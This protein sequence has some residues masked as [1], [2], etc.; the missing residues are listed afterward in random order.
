MVYYAINHCNVGPL[1]QYQLERQRVKPPPTL[2]AAAIFAIN[3]AFAPVKISWRYLNSNGSRVTALINEQTNEHSPTNGH[4]LALLKTYRHTSLRARWA[5]GNQSVSFLH[6]TSNSRRGVIFGRTCFFVITVKLLVIKLSDLGKFGWQTVP[7][8]L[9]QNWAKIHVI[10]ATKM[11]QSTECRKLL[12]HLA[13][14]GDVSCA[15]YQ[16]VSWMC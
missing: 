6:R 8:D 16:L 11:P 14:R 2:H 7:V 10:G 3:G 1:D 12:R 5:D 9:G 15:C 13:K 4:S